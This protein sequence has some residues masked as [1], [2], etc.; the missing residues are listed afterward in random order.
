[1]F[2]IPDSVDEMMDKAI[3]AAIEAELVQL[4]DVTVITGGY[5]VRKA[6]TTN[7]LQVRVVGNVRGAAEKA[8]AEMLSL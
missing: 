4:N 5:P 8:A 6:G 2:E 1:L 7:V 3:Q